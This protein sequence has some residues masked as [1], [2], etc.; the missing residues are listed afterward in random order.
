MNTVRGR[1]ALAAMSFAVAGSLSACA[2]AP[3]I[4]SREPDNPAID[5]PGFLESADH[6]AAHRVDRRVSE[7]DFIRMSREPGTVILDAR[8]AEKFAELHVAGAIN[9][10]FPDIT[11]ASLAQA[12]PDKS[13]RVLIY[14]NN[15]FVNSEQAF[16]TKMATVALNLSTYVAL[17]SHG[18]RNVFELG[19]QLDPATA[20]L[21]LEGTLAP[22]AVA[23]QP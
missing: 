7:A 3:A 15:N 6:A 22:R 11:I 16:P 23:Q 14:C 4:A 19:P 10:S 8:S 13:A 9:L 18:Y 17:Y 20:R 1:F 5:M 21:P 2:T 12:I